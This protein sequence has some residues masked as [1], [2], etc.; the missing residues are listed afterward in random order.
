[1]ASEFNSTQKYLDKDGLAHFFGILDSAWW[2]KKYN[3][4]TTDIDNLNTSIGELIEDELSN[5]LP[6]T[7]GSDKKITG[8]L[9]VG[10]SESSPSNIFIHGDIIPE[11]DGKY[12]LGKPETGQGSGN[13]KTWANI[14]SNNII[15]G[16]LTVTGQLSGELSG[17]SSSA[18]KTTGS[19]YLYNTDSSSE[20]FKFD[21]STNTHVYAV[22]GLT[23][24]PITENNETKQNYYQIGHS[25]KIEQ[26][27]I[28]SST[29]SVDFG[30]TIS[31]PKITYDE[32]GHITST[33]TTS[34]KIQT[35]NVVSNDELEEL[36]NNW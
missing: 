9:H 18:S 30:G 15:T 7:A 3:I 33:G 5:Y 12:N 27:T 26:G 4:V 11:S 31:I 29:E 23:F 25:N 20:L 2:Q 19:L 36:F 13:G 24:I 1:M 35:Y 10:S 17:N 21:G 8:N 6:L 16:N 34:I 32:H 14:Y 22:D 28:E